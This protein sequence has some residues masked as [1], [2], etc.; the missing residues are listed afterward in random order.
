MGGFIRRGLLDNSS[1]AYD[2]H[3]DNG[4]LKKG[5]I[6]YFRNSQLSQSIERDHRSQPNFPKLNIMAILAVKSKLK[7]QNLPAVIR[8]LNVAV[9]QRTAKKCTKNY[10]ARTKPMAC[11]RS[12]LEVA[13]IFMITKLLIIKLF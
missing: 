12:L 6:F 7:C 2:G 9:L 11:H 13:N 8:V 1:N 4:Q 3:P 10:N 5:F